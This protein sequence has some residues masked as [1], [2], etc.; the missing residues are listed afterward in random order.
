MIGDLESHDQ[1]CRALANAVPCTVIAVDY[2]LAPEHKFP[3]AVEDAMAAT[4]WIADNAD[5]LKVDAKRLAVAGDSAGGNLAAVVS[6]A[7]RDSG[8]PTPVLQF[9]IY[10]GTDMAMQTVSIRPACRAAA[11]DEKR[12]AMVRR[13]L[14]ARAAGRARL[15][16]LAAA[17]GKPAGPAAGPYHYGR[18]R[19]ARAMKA[20]P[21]PKRFRVPVSP[22]IWSV[23]RDKFTGLSPWGGSSP[24]PGAPPILAQHAC[25]QPLAS[26]AMAPDYPQHCPWRP[27]GIPPTRLRASGPRFAP[28]CRSDGNGHD[29]RTKLSG[30]AFWSRLHNSFLLACLAGI[31][32]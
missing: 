32:E 4:R 28:L 9:L 22:L 15:A 26:N 7:A 14:F 5:R 3:A 20:K 25:A 27:T 2:R 8:G 21:L 11:A 10:P 6:I 24:M 19:P 30:W 16:C 29:R 31:N 23:S 18:L 13:P 1:L 17:G 12:H